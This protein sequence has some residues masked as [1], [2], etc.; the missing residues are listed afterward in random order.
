V[1]HTL[2]YHALGA[3]PATLALAVL[4]LGGGRLREPTLLAVMLAA[5]A[6]GAWPAA[7]AAAAG[8]YSPWLPLSGMEAGCLVL[9]AEAV[10]QALVWLTWM[11]VSALR[12]A[13]GALTLAAAPLSAGS[14]A[15]IAAAVVSA[16]AAHPSAPALAGIIVLACACA[17]HTPANSVADGW[18][19]VHLAGS[20]P[21]LTWLYGWAAAGRAYSYPARS[22]E[23]VL[24]ALAGLHAC[25]IAWALPRNSAAERLRAPH[26]AACAS[27]AAVAA[28][29]GLW[30]H[31]HVA[32]YASAALQLWDL[33]ARAV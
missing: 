22:P 32:L 12:R 20:V 3:V 8:G 15:A 7:A 11:W 27:A 4:H 24:L 2:R 14:A 28:L 16:S 33:L 23:R 13:G 18:L 21:A 9:A 29:W 30:G 31:L 26:A 19:V 6:G 25:S 1:A 10:F 17:A 5:A